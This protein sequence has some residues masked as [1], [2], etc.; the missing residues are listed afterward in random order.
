MFY[1]ATS[2]TGGCAI[3]VEED[4]EEKAS[5]LGGRTKI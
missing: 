5:F 3:A 2:A 1:E 4:A